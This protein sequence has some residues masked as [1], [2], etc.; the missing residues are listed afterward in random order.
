VYLIGLAKRGTGNGERP[1]KKGNCKKAEKKRT[2]VK[3]LLVGGGELI[4]STK[5]PTPCYDQRKKGKER[6]GKGQRKTTRTKGKK[7]NN[8]HHRA[9]ERQ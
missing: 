7:G 2:I 5:I 9:A 1:T 3:D 4:N 8:F 6:L